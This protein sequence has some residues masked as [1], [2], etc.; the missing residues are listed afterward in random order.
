MRDGSFLKQQP[1]LPTSKS[2]PEGLIHFPFQNV[3]SLTF[4]CRP[5]ASLFLIMSFTASDECYL[6]WPPSLPGKG[7]IKIPILPLEELLCWHQLYSG[8]LLK[9]NKK[10]LPNIISMEIISEDGI[11][12]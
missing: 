4:C 7:Q 10:T 8:D 12:G 9:V 1:S 11:C 6:H 2:L 3:S 5:D